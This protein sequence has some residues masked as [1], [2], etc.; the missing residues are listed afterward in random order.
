[1]ADMELRRR[2]ADGSIETVARVQARPGEGARIEAVGRNGIEYLSTLLATGIETG[3]GSRL[4]PED[5]EAFVLAL[6]SAFHG[7]RFWA[8][9][10]TDE[11]DGA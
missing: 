6:P 2:R 10:V 11:A 4:Y 9:P 1:M 8:E 5:G 3:G 7:T